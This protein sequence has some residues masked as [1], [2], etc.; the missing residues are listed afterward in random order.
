MARQGKTASRVA[1]PETGTGS[2]AAPLTR[3]SLSC[4]GT[5]V[6]AGTFGDD[7]FVNLR[8][9]IDRRIP[10]GLR[11]NARAALSSVQAEIAANRRS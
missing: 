6:V 3:P 8:R 4:P 10:P 9:Y 5:A 11:R 7:P 1:G 2:G